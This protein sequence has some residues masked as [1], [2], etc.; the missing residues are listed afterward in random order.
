MNHSIWVLTKEVNDYEQD[1]EYFCAIFSRKPT[2]DELSAEL[3]KDWH[4]ITE[5]IVHHVLAGG[6]RLES[7]DRWWFLRK[8]SFSNSQS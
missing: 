7:E 1:G 2:Y 4:S 3:N 5:C 6:G 8:V